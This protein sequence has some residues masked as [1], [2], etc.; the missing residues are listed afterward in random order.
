MVCDYYYREGTPK[1][2]AELWLVEPNALTANI[3]AFTVNHLA[4]PDS[5][6]LYTLYSPCGMC[7]AKL[8]GG[9]AQFQHR[10]LCFTFLWIQAQ[11]T[12]NFGFPDVG[13]AM[14]QL[15]N[16]EFAASPWTIKQ[17]PNPW[18]EANAPSHC[19]YPSSLA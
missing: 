11:T 3:N 17:F 8:I 7:S 13:Q 19:L 6:Y 12:T 14:Q 9:G 15:V 16:M 10:S 18:N 5:I 2:H 1:E 4:A